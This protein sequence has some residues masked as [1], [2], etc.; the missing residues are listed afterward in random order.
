MNET[1]GG[2]SHFLQLVVEFAMLMFDCSVLGLV[3]PRLFV[4]APL[5][6]NDLSWV[7]FRLF[8]LRP[9]EVCLPASLAW[10]CSLGRRAR[11]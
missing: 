4:L 9:R 10:F 7:M 11:F 5:A 2:L 8:A 1:T 3:K 6:Q